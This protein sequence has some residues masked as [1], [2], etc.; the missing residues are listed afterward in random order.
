MMVLN[1]FIT[2]RAMRQ[3]LRILKYYGATDEDGAKT[4]AELGLNP[5]SFFERFMRLRDHKPK[6][7][8]LLVN[9]DIV[10]I[11]EDGRIYLSEEKLYASNIVRKWPSVVKNINRG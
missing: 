7:L 1:L 8:K 11:T 10:Q 9:L 5:P 3:V 4:P 2:K 6:T